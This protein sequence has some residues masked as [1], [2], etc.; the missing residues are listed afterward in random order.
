MDHTRR[1][2]LYVPDIGL[3]TIGLCIAILTVTAGIAL[4]TRAAT[5]GFV[6]HNTPSYTATAK[7]LGAEDPAKVI[8][9][10]LWLNPHKQAELDAVA[11]DLYD[12]DSPNYRKFLTMAQIAARF[13]PTVAEAKTVSQF[14]EAHSLKVVRVGPH[15]FFVR[16]RGTVHDV[17]AAFD[18]QLNQY[19]LMGKVVRANDR[20]PFIE[21]EAALLVRAVYGLDS[22]EFH[23]P[24]Q[25]RP[26]SVSQL[27][28]AK[29]GAKDAAAAGALKS[30][31]LSA[32]STT[33]FFSNKCFLGTETAVFS[34]NADGEFP[35]G[36]YK[37]NHLNLPSQTSLG[38]GYTPPMIHAAYD[39]KD[40]YAAGLDGRGQTIA[41][42]DSCGTPS[43]EI[44]ANA[45]SAKFGL[46]PLT[47][48]NFAIIDVPPPVTCGFDG[49]VEVNLDVEW[50]HAIAPGANINLLLAPSSTVTD[51]DEAQFLAVSNH[52][53]TVVSGSF[54]L[55]EPFLPQTEL[56]T[57]NMI[58]EMGAMTGISMNFSTGDFGDFSFFFQP[59]PGGGFP[60]AV[61]A[62]ASSPFA[63]AVGG[64]SLELNADNSIR[65]QAGWGTN[66]VAIANSGTVFD[67]PFFAAL[68]GGSG[69]GASNCVQQTPVNN[70]VICLDGFPKPS[71]QN[72]LPGTTRQ[73]PD[74]SWLADPFTG[75][76]IAFTVPG[77]FP[78][79]QF[80]V[81]GGTSLSCPMFSA[82]WAIANQAAG[83][84]LGQAAPYLY[85]LPK[86][87]ILDVVPVGAQPLVA[88]LIQHNVTGSIQESSTMTT[89]FNAAQ[90]LGG[91][92]TVPFVSG[93]FDDPFIFDAGVV[94]SFDTD[95]DATTHFTNFGT[96]CTDPNR[97]HTTVGWDNV[98]G[99]GVPNGSEF[100]EA[101]ARKPVRED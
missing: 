90:M 46:P 22:I 1:R 67:P 20:D 50:A 47:K 70:G 92:I 91:N 36:T 73:L 88:G 100:I 37:G 53:G 79:Q 26:T 61:S 3:R 35:I 93:I 44:D 87:A 6:S 24:V 58:S 85:S 18:V 33:D 81:I 41:I 83:R 27:L 101:F 57:E 97:L 80:A 38:C 72:K 71:F 14:L 40:L 63:T 65:W 52:L 39:L 82:L 48:K 78:P 56:E 43:I 77:V 15:N 45:F 76:V 21:G 34:T 94:I 30:N 11:N 86:D 64:I 5:G 10:S 95:C 68:S 59:F 7:L 51:L 28:E 60:Q 25:L 19:E 4:P 98:T 29:M 66:L 96:L 84:P 75:A 12:P 9:V 17:Q 69:G 13:A 62:P 8:E 31:S 16:A 23:S 54:G 42:I 74:I 2:G 55:P 49:N 89:K 32:A 99:L